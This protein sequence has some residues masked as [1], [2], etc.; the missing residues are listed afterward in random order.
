MEPFSTLA[1]IVICYYHQEW[2][3]V[4]AEK[5]FPVQLFLFLKQEHISFILGDNTKYNNSNGLARWTS[6]NFQYLCMATETFKI[7]DFQI[8]QVFKIYSFYHS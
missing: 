5:S 1:F 6:S 7:A 8:I 4:K 2:T 3:I